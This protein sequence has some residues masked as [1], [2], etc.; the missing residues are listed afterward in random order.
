MSVFTAAD[1]SSRREALVLSGAVLA[2]RDRV[3]IERALTATHAALWHHGTDSGSSAHPLPVEVNAA[4]V[5]GAPAAA[6]PNPVRSSRPTSVAQAA[7][8]EARA[9]MLHMLPPSACSTAHPSQSSLPTLPL[10]A[11][12]RHPKVA[13]LRRD[14]VTGRLHRARQGDEWKAWRPP[15]HFGIVGGARD[16]DGGRE[17][18]GG[19][20]SDTIG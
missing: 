2:E 6:A 18:G 8:E 3:A 9:D 15:H 19:S 1:V 4:A 17:D 12:A 16:G 14:P 13:W 20:S 10:R 11:L 5:G 7:L